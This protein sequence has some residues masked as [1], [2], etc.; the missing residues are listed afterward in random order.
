[1]IADDSVLHVLKSYISSNARIYRVMS[2]CVCIQM[3]R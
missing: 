3:A 1:M 2:V